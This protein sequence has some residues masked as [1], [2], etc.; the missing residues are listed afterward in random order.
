MPRCWASLPCR[1]CRLLQVGG[2][3]SCSF[4]LFT[5]EVYLSGRSH[6]T[7]WNTGV[8]GWYC[9][10]TTSG[11]IYLRSG[12]AQIRAPQ[13][14]PHHASMSSVWQLAYTATWLRWTKGKGHRHKNYSHWT[15]QARG[16]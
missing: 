11:E 9:A 6:G 13:T 8:E 7:A 3:A 4:L 1:L 15:T 5:P 10:S 12:C 2:S 16:L 14:C